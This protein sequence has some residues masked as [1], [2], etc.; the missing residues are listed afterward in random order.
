MK[1][2]GSFFYKPKP[3]EGE[4]KAKRWNIFAIMGRAIRKTCTA[5][6][7][8]FL[9][10]II[11]SVVMVSMMGGGEASKPLPEEMVLVFE[12]DGGVAELPSRPSLLEP[13]PFMQPTLRNVIDTIDKAREDSRVKGLVVNF[14]SGGMSVAHIQELRT[15]ISRFKTSGK[16][17]KIYATSYMDGMA[18]LTQYYFASIFDEIWMQPIGM[19]SISGMSMEMPFAKEAM[20][21]IGVSAQFFQREEYKSAMENFTNSSMSQEN[22][23]ALNEMIQSLT[24]MMVMDISKDRELSPEFVRAQIDKA[25]LSGAEALQAKLIDRLDYGDVLVSE[26]RQELKGDPEDDTLELITL[27]HYSKDKK[28]AKPSIDKKSIALIYTVGAIMEGSVDQGAG[29]DDIA[30]AITAAY[31]DEDIEAIV[32]RV[33]S[34]GGS[35]SASESIRRALI[36]AQEKDKKVIVS[37]GPVAASGG[38]W[39]ATHADKIFASSGTITGSIGVV[40]GKFEAS[41]LWQNIGI[42]WEGPQIGEN[43]DIW[44]INQPFD[45]SATVRMNALIDDTYDAFL[46][47][48]A[49]GR[50]MPKDKVRSLAKGRVWTGEQAQKIG[51][52]DEI[53][54]LIEALDY[55]AT[56]L[57]Q[58]SRTDLNVIKMPRELDGLERLLELF[59]QEVSAGNF[60]GVSKP[61]FEKIKSVMAY[62]SVMENSHGHLA[63]DSN[64]EAMR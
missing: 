21:K 63:Y 14:K 50:D 25:I 15:A 7:A 4:V 46:S 64:L 60:L 56:L 16:F 20:D 52:V 19:L 24:N 58:K 22:R 32:L 23:E 45:A 35:P 38:Y 40:M 26:M 12:I 36:R 62:F 57:G 33:D 5:I 42:N 28:K 31:K 10:S 8:L 11:S 30:D 13:F 2:L 44:S 54:G 43:A 6:G 3:K 17:T 41:Q 9:I 61:T 48:V 49:E 39:V 29:A 53:G 55:T 51:L 27:S 18:G 34:P 47:R 37:M 1:K 59:G